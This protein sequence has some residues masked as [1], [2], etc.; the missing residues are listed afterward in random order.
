MFAELVGA[1]ERW[2]E[3]E[4]QTLADRAQWRDLPGRQ[5][6]TAEVIDFWEPCRRAFFILVP[7]RAEI[8]R[9]SDEAIKGITHHLV[10]KTNPK[11]L[12]WWIED[13][14]ERNCHLEAGG[15]YI[16]QREPIHWATNE[17]DTDRIHLLVEYG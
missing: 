5:Y 2:Q 8:H 15:R 11:C 6:R 16:V 17:G 7:P 10:L 4:L 1:L 3:I 14:Q 9:H 12:N 13:G